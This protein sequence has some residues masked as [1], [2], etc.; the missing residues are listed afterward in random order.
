MHVADAV[1][2]TREV[3]IMIEEYTTVFPD[4]YKQYIIPDVSL[5]DVE[6]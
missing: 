1:Q 3:M 6:P 5:S 4:H 2:F